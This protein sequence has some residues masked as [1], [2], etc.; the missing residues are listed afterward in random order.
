MRLQLGT[1]LAGLQFEF[2]SVKK[3]EAGAVPDPSGERAR[4][5]GEGV[6]AGG[7]VLGWMVVLGS[8]RRRRS[9]RASQ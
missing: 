9:V 5:L 4:L 8:L 6:G 2:P 1:C 3:F 7:A